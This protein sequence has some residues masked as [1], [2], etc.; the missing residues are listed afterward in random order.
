VTVIVLLIAI[1]SIVQ[2]GG[3][4]LVRRIVRRTG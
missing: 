4:R 3:D 2:W 1:V